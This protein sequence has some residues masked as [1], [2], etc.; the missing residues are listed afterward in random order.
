M[1]S[2]QRFLEV[3]ALMA[4]AI[5]VLTASGCATGP[6][7]ALGSPA[8]SFPSP[9]SPSLGAVPT[10]PPRASAASAASPSSVAGG[11]VAILS[12][13]P[14]PDFQPEIS[15]SGAIGL[16]D[17]VAIVALTNQNHA[18][19]PD[20]VLRDY[21]DVA[22][23]RTV[24]TFGSTWPD[25][26]LDPHHLVIMWGLSMWGGRAD[27]GGWADTFAVVDIPEVQYHWFKLPMPDLRALS[28]REYVTLAPDGDATLWVWQ[29][30]P[31]SGKDQVHIST[32][33]GDR[34][35]ATLEGDGVD[36]CGTD[37][38]SRG[39]Q[40]TRSGSFAYVLDQ[41]CPRSSLLV[42]SG[43]VPVFSLTAPG[44][45][46]PAGSNPA[47]AV[48][49]PTSD[50]L[51]YRQGDNV[52]KWVRGGPPVLFLP[53]VRWYHPT[54]SPDGVHLAYSAAQP[55]G[56][57]RVY[58]ADLARGGAPQQVGSGARS[59]PVFVNDTQLWYHSDGVDEEPLVYNVADGS[60]SP[61]ALAAVYLVWP[62]TAATWPWQ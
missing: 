3:A 17:P 62:G 54:I 4:A 12:A 57:R 13:S 46:W 30:P 39:A 25:Q 61:S 33:S 38:T 59:H 27:T 37:E 58:V 31:G 48:W 52:W 47:M 28:Y 53:G 5:L 19:P 15:C 22:R 2:E 14:P 45:V 56:S 55:D 20:L 51:Y 18:P 35:V 36:E 23:P 10:I 16:S 29:Y 49:S 41:S 40:F 9:A 44:G 34:E 50:T 8:S 42:L 26:I 32:M 43:H 21:A 7:A 6:P 24:C 60:E 11:P 1:R